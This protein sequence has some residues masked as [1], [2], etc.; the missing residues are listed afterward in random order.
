[1]GT[2]ANISQLVN[3]ESGILNYPRE[4]TVPVN[5]DHHTICKFSSRLDPNYV[6][7]TNLLRQITQPLLRYQGKEFEWTT[8][9]LHTLLV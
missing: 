3:K 4:I 6:L 5:A 2:N 7:V 9:Y 1:M 8:A